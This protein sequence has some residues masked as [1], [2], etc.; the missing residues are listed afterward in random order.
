MCSILRILDSQCG[1]FSRRRKSVHK[2]MSP[3]YGRSHDSVPGN[4]IFP[5]ICKSDMGARKDKRKL[6]LGGSMLDVVGVPVI[7]IGTYHVKVL[8][9]FQLPT[10]ASLPRGEY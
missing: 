6:L 2:V 5:S 4:F 3:V 1:D 9:L 10:S 8:H 7:S